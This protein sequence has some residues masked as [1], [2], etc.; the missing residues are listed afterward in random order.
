[1]KD[2][3]K[4]IQYYPYVDFRFTRGNIDV[5]SDKQFHQHYELYFLLNGD[6]TFVNDHIHQPLEP[7]NLVIIPPRE[8][9]SFIAREESI[10]DYSRCVLNISPGLL[11]EEILENALV[12][13]EVLTLPPNHRIT[14]HFLYLK[15]AITQNNEEDFGYI[16]SAIATD[17][18]FLIKQMPRTAPMDSCSFRHPLSPQIMGYINETYKSDLT[19]EKIAEHFYLSP[20]SA[21]HIF[22]N[23]FGI[24]I[25]K[26]ILQ[27][28]VTEARFDIRQGM[29]P[30]EVSLAYGFTNYSTFY[31]AYKKQFGVSPSDKHL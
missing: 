13:R 9:H 11:S 3:I 22:K 23:D 25:K 17:I 8:Y 28:R 15:K 14:E 1:M 2:A 27:K 10:P 4:I 26:Y 16:L 29:H 19:L 18:V 12:G 20:S 31:R 7:Y 30:E 6:V 24:S 21:S 5:F